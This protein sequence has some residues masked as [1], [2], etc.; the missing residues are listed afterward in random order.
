M[1]LHTLTT[2]GFTLIE[3][4]VS[5]AIFS[6][7]MVIAVGSL[8]SMMDANRKAQALKSSINNL[9][10]AL[11]NMSRQIRSGST[12]HCGVGALTTALDCP[13]GGSQIA[14]EPYGG[15][16]SNANDQVVYRH[17][18]ARI[19]RSTN[20]GATFLPITSPEVTVEDLT[21]Y[22]VGSLPNDFPMQQPKVVITLSGYAGV[23]DRTRTEVRL[24][25]MITSRLLD[26]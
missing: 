23:T 21:F 19:E 15:S 25:T 4:M 20:G 8:F 7:V 14:F 13:S 22:V 17:A 12:Y 18:G 1:R 9:A 5:V 16:A 24:Q 11:E 10:F 2:K 6:I 26:E 3:L